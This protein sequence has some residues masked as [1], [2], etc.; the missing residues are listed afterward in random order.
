ML[1]TFLALVLSL[2]LAAQNISTFFKETFEERLRDDPEFATSVGRHDYDD[3]W[4]D[5][6]KAGR[7]QRRAHLEQRLRQLSGFPQAGLNPQD[8]LSARLLDYLLRNQLESGGVEDGL[9]R[10][11]Q[12][13]G[14]HNRVYSVFDRMPARTARDYQ[15]LLARLRGVPAYIDQNIALLGDFAS[16][17]GETEVPSGGSLRS[18]VPGRLAQIPG[19]PLRPIHREGAPYCR[20]EQ[21]SRWR[22]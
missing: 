1:R 17:P 22:Q 7:E 8:R 6:S 9:L 5:W 3:R 13:N 18:P 4:N 21:Y 11:T 12:Q 19:L 14:L 16:R 15:N 2:P 10:V 20:P